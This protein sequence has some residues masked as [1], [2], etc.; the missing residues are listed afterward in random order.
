MS[1]DIDSPVVNVLNIVLILQI[2]EN[3]FASNE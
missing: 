1:S 3:K 2:S